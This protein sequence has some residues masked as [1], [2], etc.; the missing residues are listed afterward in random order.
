MLKIPKRFSDKKNKEFMKIV[1]EIRK[2]YRISIKSVL[3]NI[4]YIYNKNTKIKSNFSEQDKFIF[5]NYYNKIKLLLD[6]DF[7]NYLYNLK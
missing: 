2:R 6:F 1:L 3:D 7:F 5:R 4:L